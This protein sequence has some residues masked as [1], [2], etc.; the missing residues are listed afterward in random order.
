[1]SLRTITQFLVLMLLAA[2]ILGCGEQ[3]KEV[4]VEQSS[5]RGI[6]EPRRG[7][8]DAT[9][10]VSVDDV[11]VEEFLGAGVQCT[12]Y[13]WFNIS[14]AVWQKTFRRMDYLKIPFTRVMCDWTSFFEGLDADGNPK[15]IFESQKMRNN[16]KLLDYCQENDM[17]VM[18]GHWGWTNTALHA[19][20]QNWDIAPDSEMH[21]RISADLIDYVVN[22]KGYSCIKWFDTIN[23]PDGDWSS[24]DGDWE[25]WKRVAKNVGKEIK[26]RGLDKK[27]KISGPAD[28]YSKWVYKALEDDELKSFM[29]SYNQHHYLWNKV[30]LNGDFEKNIK[31]QVAAVRAEDPGKHYF[32]A[33]LGFLD[34]KN[35]KTDQQLEIKKF[36]YGVS[37]ADAA[38]QLMRGGANGYLAWYLDDVMHWKGDSDGPLEEPA[39]AYEIR[40]TWGMWNGLGKEHGDPKD[41]ELRPWF[42]VW[43]QLSRNFPPGCKIVSVS[44][45]GVERL[46]ATAARIGSSDMSF[47]IVNNS[48][49]KRTIKLVAPELKDIVNLSRFDYFDGNKDNEVDSW[50]VTVDARGRDIY[51]KANVVLNGVD[52]SKGLNVSLPSQGVVILTTL[53]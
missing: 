6:S 39:N 35:Q 3:E 1:M 22:K 10:T 46:R 32:A 2:S 9:I 20:D 49:E 29:G 36:W 28:C 27:I 40:K 33:E 17:L 16:Y 52:L 18:F 12:G 45:S 43:S 11:I 38:I 51:P 25:L 48:D 13:P 53:Q 24:C 5:E 14:E 19:E 44:D 41:E 50:P 15:Y 23:E 21:A 37:M 26:K 34:G 8:L 7:G 30:V 4:L 47:A 31:G 42:Y